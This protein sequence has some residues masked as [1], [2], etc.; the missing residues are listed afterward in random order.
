MTENIEVK[1]LADFLREFP[2]NFLATDFERKFDPKFYTEWTSRR[3]DL[4]IGA[5]LL[6]SAMIRFGPGVMSDGLFLKR[7]DYEVTLLDAEGKETATKETMTA[8]SMRRV[9][10]EGCKE[11]IKKIHTLLWKSTFAL[12]EK[13]IF[14]ASKGKEK[15]FVKGIVTNVSGTDIQIIKKP[16]RAF[17]LRIPLAVWNFF[18]SFFSFIGMMRTVPTLLANIIEYRWKDTICLPARTLKDGTPHWA[19]GPCGVWVM[20]FIFSKLPELVDTLFIVLRRKQLIFLHW[21]HHITVL[22][23][24]WSAY[25]TNAASGL[26]FVGM[27]Y[28]VH[29]MMYGYY[30]L[31]ALE[32]VPK[33]FPTIL[34]TSSQIIQML[35]GTTVCVAAWYFHFDDDT[36]GV[37]RED[38]CQNQIGN[39]IGGGI[40]YASYLYLFLEFAV[41]K[42]FTPKN[43]GKG[44]DL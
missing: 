40:M 2:T 5:V 35:I 36:K 33:W 30:C 20:F 38:R 11:D 28:T 9:P 39:L 6:Y 42:Y 12:G 31:Q 22:L 4:C 10:V 44:K 8:V 14:Q 13:V 18:L 27:N 29:A 1:A 19:S 24:C 43:K 21:Y 23:F 32:M 16:D 3:W 7:K 25:S 15:N 37:P 34:I 26:Y 17:D 41:G